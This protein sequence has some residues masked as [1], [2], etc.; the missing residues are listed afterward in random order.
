MLIQG[1]SQEV[2]FDAEAH[3][4]FLGSRELKSVSAIIR[5]VYSPKSWDGVDP[6]VVEKARDRGERVDKYLSAYVG[7]G[8]V[9]IPYGESDDVKERFEIAARL[10][11]Q[12]YPNGIAVHVQHIVYSEEDGIAGTADFLVDGETIVDLKN[13]YRPE[14]SW[15]LQIGAYSAYSG[16]TNARVLHISPK[17]HPSGGTW[18]KYNV[19]DCKAIW[20]DAVKWYKRTLE[21]ERG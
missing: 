3:R 19:A 21:M 8:N 2:R 5:T 20:Q 18:L 16:A 14:H 9:I 15:K 7:A 4:Y 6:D 1:A 13:T 11:D 12:A 10:W 17:V